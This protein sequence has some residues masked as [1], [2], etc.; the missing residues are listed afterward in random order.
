MSYN[1]LIE[2]LNI[3]LTTQSNIINKYYNDIININSKIISIQDNINTI[4]SNP[5]DKLINK[6]LNDVSNLAQTSYNFALDLPDIYFD[7]SVNDNIIQIIQRSKNTVFNTNKLILKNDFTLKF[8]DMDKLFRVKY[9][10]NNVSNLVV[11]IYGFEDE[12]I[13]V[14]ETNIQNISHYIANIY[15]YDVSLNKN[16]DL[17]IVNLIIKEEENYK[18][19]VIDGRT[20][21]ILSSVNINIL[22]D[23]PYYH[24]IGTPYVDPGFTA[25]DNLGRIVNVIT[26]NNIDINNIGS[27]NVIYTATDLSG[28]DVQQKR[29]VNVI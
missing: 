27:Y 14:I 23:N 3:S 5:L 20:M 16:D 29:I 19:L 7:P 22:G 17:D 26:T 15:T 18:L 12:I 6:L 21:R 1:L 28:N 9:N 10:N 25:T 24:S 13:D 11:Y 2:D 4:L 8:N